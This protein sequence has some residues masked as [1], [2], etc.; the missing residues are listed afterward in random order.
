MQAVKQD[1][2]WQLAFPVTEK[3]LDDDGLDVSDSAQFVWREWPEPEGY[4]Q[5]DDGRVACKIFRTLPR[6]ASG[7]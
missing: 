5:N 4:V 1:G 3:E 7:T 2:D 6:A